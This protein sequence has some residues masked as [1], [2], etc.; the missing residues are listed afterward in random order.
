MQD[1]TNH[2]QPSSQGGVPS[3]H[4]TD[5]GQAFCPL[6]PSHIANPYTFYARARQEEPVFFSPFLNAWVVT[7]YEDVITALKDHRRFAM[8]MQQM[9]LEKFTPQVLALFSTNPLLQTPNLTVVDPPEHTRLRG[10]L[11]KALSVQR[12]A[13]LEPHIRSIADQ[14]IDHILS[15]GRMD[16]LKDVAVPYPF[17]VIGSLLNVPEADMEQIQHWSE[18]YVTLQYAAP[19]ADQQLLYAQHVLSFME[20][21][22]ALAEER[23]REPQD[24]LISDLFQ[25]TE[26]GLLALSPLEV[27][28]LL[29]TLIL[30]GFETMVNF[31]A[32][33]LYH[34]LAERNQWE[35]MVADPSCIPQ[36]VEESLRFDPPGLAT[37]RVTTEAVVLGGKSIPQGAK[38]QVVHASASHDEALFPDPETF[39]PSREQPTRHLAFGHGIHFCIGAPLARLESR[40]LLEQLCQRLP[41]LRLVPGQDVSYTP[42]LIFHGLKQVLV[43]WDV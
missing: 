14:L 1:A 6:C 27:A 21:V 12:I 16:F 15:W 35:V 23:R 13:R 33:C 40:V 41:S 11:T 19:P 7:R 17:Q 37:M 10:C 31:L 42:N 22:Q 26:A 38:V 2:Q 24:D 4:T 25:A 18:D 34:L 3:A 9:G 29:A 32:N 43:E 28:G 20:Y 8:A 5:L 30:A 36:I 39:Q